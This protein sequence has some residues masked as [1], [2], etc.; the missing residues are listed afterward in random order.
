MN[1]TTNGGA[2]PPRCVGGLCIAIVRHKSGIDSVA[3]ALVKAMDGS[4]A[5]TGILLAGSEF[6]RSP[7]GPIPPE[8]LRRGIG[9]VVGQ[10]DDL[11]AEANMLFG[12]YNAGLAAVE[13]SLRRIGETAREPAGIV[14][15]DEPKWTEIGRGE[16]S[17][18]PVAPRSPAAVQVSFKQEPT[19][20]ATSDAMQY[21]V[22][23]S[24]FGAG[25]MTGSVV[26][27]GAQAGSMQGGSLGPSTSSAS[28]ASGGES[29]GLDR[30]DGKTP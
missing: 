27:L 25:A 6:A 22:S 19:V 7:F 1:E 17:R 4:G 3:A 11:V 24:S 28:G 13:E 5:H 8:W 30:Q 12:E 18:I 15:P 2:M 16:Q 21:A 9:I 29:R 23:G 10:S 14:E 20:M 26:G